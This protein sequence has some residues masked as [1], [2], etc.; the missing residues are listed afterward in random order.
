LLLPKPCSTRNAPRFARL[1]PV[2]HAHIAGQLQP[3]EGKVTLSSLM[4]DSFLLR[5]HPEEAAK[6]RLEAMAATSEL[7]PW[8][9]TRPSVAPHH[10]ADGVGAHAI[11]IPF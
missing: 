8:F 5:P 11:S 6:P 3:A 7:L 9:E 2:G 10:E 1:E 4:R